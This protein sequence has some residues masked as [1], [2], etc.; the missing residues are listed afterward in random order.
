LIVVDASLFAAWLLNEPD[1]GPEHAVWDTLSAETIFVPGHWPNEIADAL[2]RAVR[3]KRLGV[4]EISPIAE[5]VSLFEIGFAEPTPLDEIG[6]LALEALEFGLSAYD[7]TYV[8]LARDYQY[9]LATID[10]AMRDAARRLHISL[11]P[12]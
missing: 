7:M 3:T 9:P 4:D 8:R 2:R 5:R 12:A 10:G 6:R 11:L 1:P